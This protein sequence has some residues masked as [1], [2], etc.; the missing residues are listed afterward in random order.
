MILRFSRK[1]GRFVERVEIRCN[2]TKG[3]LK[4]LT[5]ADRLLRADLKLLLLV[6]IMTD[7]NMLD[8]MCELRTTTSRGGFEISAKE[9]ARV[10]RVAIM[11][12]WRKEKC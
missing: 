4:L 1:C 11:F 12:P 5:I 2:F 9:G 3:S 6:R 10:N 8:T 7:E